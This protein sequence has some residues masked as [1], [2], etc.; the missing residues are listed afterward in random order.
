MHNLNKL[1]HGHT[2]GSILFS[3]PVIPGGPELSHFSPP[4]GNFTIYLPDQPWPDQGAIIANCEGSTAGQS[5][6][7][8][9]RK[10]G[11]LSLVHL[12]ATV[13]LDTWTAE[14]I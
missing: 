10:D 7:T 2:N 13:G 14:L 8:D 9:Y 4:G 6:L 11:V 12:F 3:G 1:Y 5:Y